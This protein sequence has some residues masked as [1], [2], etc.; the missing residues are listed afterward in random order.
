MIQPTPDIGHR[1]VVERLEDTSVRQV[2]R[3]PA[4]PDSSMLPDMF[5]TSRNFMCTSMPLETIQPDMTK[6]TVSLKM[7]LHQKNNTGTEPSGNG[8]LHTKQTTI[9]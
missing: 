1:A 3:F 2:R 4:S 6:N 7:T 8:S 9:F 5:E